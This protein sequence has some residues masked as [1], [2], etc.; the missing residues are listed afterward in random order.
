[1]PLDPTKLTRLLVQLDDPP[2]QSAPEMAQRWADALVSY[3]G[4]MTYL[5]PG[6]GQIARPLL[7]G[8]LI[9]GFLPVSTWPVLCGVIEV[10]L[11]AYWA[12]TVTPATVVI[13]SGVYGP[14]P[15]PLVGLLAPIPAVGIVASQDY[16]PRAA[17]AA[18]IH[19]W[20]LTNTVVSPG[21]TV[22]PFI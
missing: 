4:D 21:P 5:I 14:S 9:P 10:S 17:I 15:V 12:L 8:S 7:L 1:M 3:A 6:A 16:P 19:A 20:T 22:T 11:R 2:A 13:P 18:A